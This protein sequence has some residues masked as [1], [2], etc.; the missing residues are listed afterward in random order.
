MKIF[1][2]IDPNDYYLIGV[3]TA[4]SIDNC[5]SAIEVYSFKNFEQ[6]GELAI[7]L[8]SLTEYADVVIAAAKHFHEKTGG[9][10]ILCIENNTIGLSIVESVVNSDYVYNLY[11][12]P[13][14]VDK[15]GVVM[16]WG[17]ST[18]AKTKPIMISEAYYHINNTPQYFHSQDLVSQLNSLERNNAGQV[19]SRSYTDM[20]MATCFCAYVRKMKELD[21]LPQLQYDP[22]EVMEDN[23][24]SLQTIISAISPVQYAKEKYFQNQTFAEEEF[25]PPQDQSINHLPFFF[26]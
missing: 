14:K 9:R 3:D 24:K 16:Q 25:I 20:F 12:D 15:N 26:K 4:I 5:F 23:F 2:E 22:K 10:I 19:S 18:N 1:K 17:I 6:V 13:H 8:G 21:I 7:R 11:H